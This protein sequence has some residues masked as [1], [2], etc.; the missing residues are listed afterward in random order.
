MSAESVAMQYLNF[1][2]SEQSR[3]PRSLRVPDHSWE[4]LEDHA[5]ELGVKPSTLAADLLCDAIND[6][7]EF[8]TRSQTAN[9]N[10]DQNA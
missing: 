10:G 2:I 1:S 4:L 5:N 7:E 6:L 8:F 9:K 3:S